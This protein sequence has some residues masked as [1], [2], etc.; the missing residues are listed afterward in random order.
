MCTSVRSREKKRKVENWNKNWHEAASMA[1][2]V[3]QCVGAKYGSVKEEW[4]QLFCGHAGLHC[5]LAGPFEGQQQ[6]LQ[7]FLR[8]MVTT[9]SPQLP[10]YVMREGRKDRSFRF[11]AH[12]FFFVE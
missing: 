9:L 11:M 5:H 7:L 4:K 10:D 8:T 12:F 6:A 2:E 1:E 3:P